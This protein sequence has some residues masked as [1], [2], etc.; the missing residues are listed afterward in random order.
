MRPSSL[1]PLFAPVS[2]LPGVGSR[3]AVRLAS[4]LGTDP[5]REPHVIDLLMH[6]PSGIIDRRLRPGIA[7]APEGA[8]V[9]LE[10]RIDR[11]QAPPRAS[12]APYRIFGHDDSGEIAFVF[13]HANSS[14]LEKSM[15]VG[16]DLIVSGRV[17][18]FNGRPQMVHPDHV[19][20]AD[21]ADTLPLVEPV[22]PLTQGLSGKVLQ[23]AIAAGLERVPD[24]PEWLDAAHGKRANWPSFREALTAL[25]RPDE[26]R[27]AEHGEDSAALARL[28]YDEFLANQLALALVR[29]SLRQTRGI[30][31]KFDGVLKAKILAALPY[32]LTNGQAQAVTEIEEDLASPIRMLRLLQGDVGAGKTVVGLLAAAAAIESGAQTVLMAPTEILARQHHASLAPLCEAAGIR[33]AILT[34]RDGARHKR[35]T[36]AALEAGEIDLLVGTHALFQSEIAFANLGLAIVDEQ[37][38]FGV[39]QRLMLASKG[40]GVDMLVMTA[41]PIPRTLVLTYFGDME[42]SRLTEKPAGRQPI[43]TVAVPLDRMDEVVE[44]LRVALQEGKKAYWV[45]PLVEESEKS[46]LAAAEER[47]AVLTQLLGPRVALV[48]G[49]Q[50]SDE[51]DAAMRAFKDGPVQLLVA[52]TV[53]E[54]GVDVP[55]ASII[56]I[57]HAE[58]FGLS[59]LHQLRGRVGRGKEASTCLLLYKTPIGET[60][61][62]RLSIM[63]ETN[64]G[65]LIAEEDLRL[66][67]EGEILGTRQSGTPGFRI[68]DAGTQADLLET[69]RDDARLVLETEPALDGK[70][71]PH[72]KMLLYLFGRDEAVRLLRAG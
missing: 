30:G 53:I 55:E 60:A 72:L 17:E 4:L 32:S 27:L 12:R 14:W 11:H 71:G 9:T 16:A 29:R 41:T 63:R 44:R 26:A 10:V 47:H 28:S 38:R 15:P 33:L 58:R 65:F 25:H 68:A 40:Q 49:R 46:D 24:L 54:V 64:D 66:R 45:C 2:S 69:A 56:V 35:E 13:F 6:M 21:E 22:Y 34:G 36:R 43:T 67:G 1:D 51:K 57:E 7:R 50:S 8:I 5:E 19:V 70:R 37:H 48:H 3:L 59:Q 20:P 18:W 39:H 23:K 52:T 62:A 61:R 42:V 31:R